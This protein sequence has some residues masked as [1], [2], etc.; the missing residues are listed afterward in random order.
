[1]ASHDT[2]S[3]TRGTL[4]LKKPGNNQ[5]RGDVDGSFQ[6]QPEDNDGLSI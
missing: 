2:L 1:M 4:Q 5:F 6:D 3:R